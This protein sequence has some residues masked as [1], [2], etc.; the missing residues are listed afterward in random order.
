MNAEQQRAREKE[1]ADSYFMVYSGMSRR[2]EVKHDNPQAQYQVPVWDLNQVTL[3][4]LPT[5][6]YNYYMDI[7]SK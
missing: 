5:H 1:V 4:T 7:I 3:M 2:P 6:P